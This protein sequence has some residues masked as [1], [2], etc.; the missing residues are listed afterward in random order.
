MQLGPKTIPH[1]AGYELWHLQVTACL[2]NAVA[3]H[4][5]LEVIEAF[6]MVVVQR[7]KL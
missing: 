7:L 5:E 2:R 6:Q 4:D 3:T 1:G